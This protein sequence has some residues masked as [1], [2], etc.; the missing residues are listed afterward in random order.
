MKV[1]LLYITFFLTS[2]FSNAQVVINEIDFENPGANDFQ[3]IELKTP[4]SNTSLDGYVLVFYNAGS[5]P[6]AGTASYLAIDLDGKTTDINGNFLA[7]S[8]SVSPSPSLLINNAAIQIGPDVVALYSGNAIDFPIGTPA[9]T[10]NLLDAIAYSTTAGSSPTTL[11]GILGLSTCHVDNQTG[12]KSIQRLS[13]GTYVVQTPTPKANND[14]SGIPINYMT[15]TFDAPN[16]TEGQPVNITFTTTTP[17]T[18]NTNFTVSLNNGN[19]N[20]SDFTFDTDNTVTINSGSNIALKTINLTDDAFEEGDEE[21]VLL[22]SSL[23]PEVEVN[24]N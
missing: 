7:G 5:T 21:F 23:P 19:F 4:L 14:G 20:S 6:F 1:T 11:M 13:N 17:V 15:T 10:T 16:Y 22:I 3:I 12:S 2:W 8:V 18:S 9:T 24:N